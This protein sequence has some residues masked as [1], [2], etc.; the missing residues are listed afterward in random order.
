MQSAL[1]VTE[2]QIERAHYAGLRWRDMQERRAEA[3]RLLKRG[4]PELADS[5]ERVRCWR[6]REEAKSVAYARAGVTDAFFRERRI[7]P[8]LDLD[9]FPPNDA[10][11]LAGKSVGRIV[12]IDR[13]GSAIDGFATGFLISESL[14]LTNH[15]VFAEPGEAD[16]CGVQFG[17][18]LTTDRRLAAGIVFA[19]DPAAFFYANDEL[20]FAIVGVAATAFDGQRL[21]DLDHLP[22]IPVNGKILVGQAISIIQYPDGGP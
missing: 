12:Q 3:V 13:R 11:Q 17:Y 4:G 22:L 18:E 19:L 14:L 2:R 20:D 16:G 1:R 6:L 10:A 15:H 9:D 21:M 7:G 5:P 8:T